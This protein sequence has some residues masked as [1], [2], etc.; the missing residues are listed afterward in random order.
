MGSA[1][2]SLSRDASCSL[3]ALPST[4]SLPCCAAQPYPTLQRVLCHSCAI[5]GLQRDD[6]EKRRGGGGVD[7]PDELHF[8]REV[9]SGSEV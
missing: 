9:T 4:S 1:Y 3:R 7:L 6:H 8:G 5:P 2:S